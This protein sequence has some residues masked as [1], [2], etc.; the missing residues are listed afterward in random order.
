MPGPSSKP[1]YRKQRD[2]WFIRLEGGKTLSLGVHGANNIRQATKA[3]LALLCSHS[4]PTPTPLPCPQ[5]SARACSVEEAVKAFF[6]DAAA[7]IKPASLKFYR[8]FLNPF[9]AAHADRLITSITAREAHAF[10]SRPT[11]SSSTRHGALTSIRTLFRWAKLPLEGLRIPPKQS[12]GMDAVIEQA[13]AERLILLARGDMGP[14]LRFLW[15]T[16]CRPSEALNLRAETVNLA[17][18]LVTLTDHKTASRGK[19]RFVYLTS[20]AKKLIEVQIRKHGTGLLFRTTLSKR[21]TLNNANNILWRLNRRL[22]TKAT[23]YGFRHSF[24]T[25]G[26]AN[27][28]P[29]T[30]VAEL[31][32]HA[33]TKMVATHYGHLGAKV[34]QML[35]SAEAV[36]PAKHLR[37]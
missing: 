29:E 5:P 2:A 3:W 24:A 23:L 17:A 36:R 35:A 33:S 12:K 6:E 13:D 30:H 22:G 27:G 19:P 34:R 11:W 28:L 9:A 4:H 16:G 31:L 1:F 37:Y 15:L 14:L 20:E 21:I 26:L 18:S 25:D 7:R 10:A 8:R 32:G